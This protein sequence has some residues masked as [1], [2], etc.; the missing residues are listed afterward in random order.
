MRAI[1]TAPKGTTPLADATQW[2]WAQQGACNTDDLGVF[3]APDGEGP[4]GR[5]ARETVAKEICSWCPVRT[6]CAEYALSKPER[7]GVWGGMGEDERAS[8]RRRNVRRAAEAR[9]RQPQEPTVNPPS[10]EPVRVDGTGTHRRLRALSVLGFGPMTIASRMKSGSKSH[11][12]DIRDRPPRPI[13]PEVAEEVAA[14][15][16]KLL[17][18]SPGAQGPRVAAKAARQGWEGPAAWEGLDID[19]PNVVPREIAVEDTRS[20]QAAMEEARRLLAEAGITAEIVTHAP[21]A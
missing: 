20:G 14:L 3:F 1:R 19:D 12:L 15:Y 9:R 5:A 10:P 21:A 4:A 7:F 16:P 6:E 18:L 2:D 11:L 8:V 13:R 17:K